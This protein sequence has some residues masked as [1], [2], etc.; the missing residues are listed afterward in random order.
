MTI[1]HYSIIIV[2][3]LLHTGGRDV[4]D[5]SF[6]WFLCSVLDAIQRTYV[7]LDTIILTFFCFHYHMINFVDPTIQN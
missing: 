5:A 6:T 4:M 1:S 7:A 2:S 3:V